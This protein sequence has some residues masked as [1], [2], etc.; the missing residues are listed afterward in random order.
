[1][2]DY[3]EYQID[4]IAFWAE[5]Y[6]LYLDYSLAQEGDRS[7]AWTPADEA[8]LALSELRKTFPSRTKSKDAASDD[9]K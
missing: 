1:M 6:Y 7:A 4:E 2:H 5:V 3:S 8:N 9:L